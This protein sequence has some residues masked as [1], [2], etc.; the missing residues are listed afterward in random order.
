MPAPD[1]SRRDAI[2]RDPDCHVC[3]HRWH[4]LPC[5]LCDCIDHTRPGL[6]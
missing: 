5:E 2:P 3:P 1:D 4:L 6:D